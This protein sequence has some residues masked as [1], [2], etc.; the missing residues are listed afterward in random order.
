[1]TLPGYGVE[2]TEVS[3]AGG[4]SPLEINPTSVAA[5]TKQIADFPFS[6]AMGKE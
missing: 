5:E 2:I 4:Y 1:M 3:E 6:H